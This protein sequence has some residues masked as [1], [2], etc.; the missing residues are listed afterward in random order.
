MNNDFKK[1]LWVGLGVGVALML[2]S[3]AAGVV[4]KV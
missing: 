2:I 3:L 4:K 1:G